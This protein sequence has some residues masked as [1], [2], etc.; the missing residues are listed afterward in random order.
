ML[1]WNK[2]KL[3]NVAQQNVSATSSSFVGIYVSDIAQI[4][5]NPPGAIVHY[6]A[7]NQLAMCHIRTP[8]SDSLIIKT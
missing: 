7:V 8:S 3:L 6:L 5:L 2:C 1:V 4:V